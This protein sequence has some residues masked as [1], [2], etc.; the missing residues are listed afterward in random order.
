[1]RLLPAAAL[2]GTLALALTV[3][4]VF[5]DEPDPAVIAHGLQKTMG[6]DSFATARVL[7]FVWAVERDG[8]VVASY[9][10]TWDRWTGDYRLEG[11][12]RDSGEP[13]L[14]LFNVNSRDGRVW[15]GN[16]EIV[17][18]D[19][20]GHLERAY[21]RYINDTY[22]LL[23]P[24]KWL[25]PGVNLAYIG[26]ELVGEGLCDVVELTFGEVGL[27]SNDRYRGFV[28]RDSGLMVRWSYVLQDEAGEPGDGE[29]TTWDWTDWNEADPGV[30]FSQ[31]KT[32]VGGDGPP[33]AITSPTVELWIEPTA[34][35]LVA[36]FTR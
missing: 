5:A 31:R 27:T 22:W 17:G 30:W 11:V 24:W 23:M 36:W 33:V 14:A 7:R 4:P 34:E 2:T 20:A 15:L 13:W 19:L 10:H 35:Q 3:A 25:D 21:G 12:D 28:D 8:A 16:E 1:M 18:G 29:P 9:D 26:T 32:R 6:G